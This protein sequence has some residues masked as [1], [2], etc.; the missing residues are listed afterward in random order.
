[1]RISPLRDGVKLSPDAWQAV[2]T[3]AA[4]LQGAAT[5]AHLGEVSE[6]A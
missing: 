4:S 6:L 1:M 3:A 5:L 2:D